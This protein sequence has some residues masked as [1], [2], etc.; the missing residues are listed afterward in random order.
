MDGEHLGFLRTEP[1]SGFQRFLWVYLFV[2]T[3]YLEPDEWCEYLSLEPVSASLYY[4]NDYA[5]NYGLHVDDEHLGLLKTK[6]L[7]G[8]QRLL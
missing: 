1:L 8:F 3:G 7:L 6:P 5:E 2:S 4:I